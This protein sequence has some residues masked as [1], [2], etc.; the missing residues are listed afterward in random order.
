MVAIKSGTSRFFIFFIHVLTW[1]IFFT[2]APV[3]RYEAGDKL[4]SSFFLNSF[5]IVSHIYIIVLFYLNAYVLVPKLLFKKNATIFVI[6][7]LLIV[8]FAGALIYNLFPPV[9]GNQYRHNA[10]LLFSAVLPGFFV[11]AIS[12]SYRIMLDRI[13]NERTFNDR[14]NENLKTELSFLRSQISPHFMF[15]VLNNAVSLARKKS[16]LLEPTLIKISHLMRYMLY[17]SDVSKVSLELETEY[18][19][20]YIDLQKQRFGNELKIHLNITTPKRGYIEPMLLI[21]FVENAFKHGTGMIENPEISVQLSMHEKELLFSVTNTY[22]PAPLEEKDSSSGIGLKNVERRLNL[23]YGKK[24]SLVTEVK[25]NK[26]SV[27]LK[28]SL[29]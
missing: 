1:T 18:I 12:T 27:T 11:V 23:L 14:E 20:D 6:A 22:D 15:N 5:Y 13:R 21:P 7:V 19:R 3:I 28:I 26:Y 24:H 25:G 4:D 10:G 29:E 16:E 17:D 2:L 9:H 8:F